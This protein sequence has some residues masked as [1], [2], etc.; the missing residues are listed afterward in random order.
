MIEDSRDG[1]TQLI[2]S[3]GDL[4]QWLLSFKEGQCLQPVG[5]LCGVCDRIH[6]DRDHTGELMGNC[7]RCQ[8][9]LVETYAESY[10]DGVE[11]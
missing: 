1:R 4:E 2:V 7:V 8:V 11:Q 9:E 10:L 5:A 6:G 3:V